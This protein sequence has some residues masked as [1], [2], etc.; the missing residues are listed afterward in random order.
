VGGKRG[1]VLSRGGV[2]PRAPVAPDPLAHALAALS[3]LLERHPRVLEA[4]V[5]PLVATAGGVAA[6]DAL[7][8]L[9]PRR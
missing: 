8:V 7:V 9:G 4:E 2:V 1:S 3:A 6:V 5:N